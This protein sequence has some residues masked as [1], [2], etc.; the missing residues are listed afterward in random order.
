VVFGSVVPVKPGNGK[1]VRWDAC[2]GTARRG[3]SRH[4]P[5]ADVTTYTNDPEIPAYLGYGSYCQPVAIAD[6][7]LDAALSAGNPS[8]L[9][10]LVAY[11]VK[12]AAQALAVDIAYDCY[13]GTGATSVINGLITASGAAPALSA[14]G[15][16]AQV[17]RSEL[18]AYIGSGWQA[19]V[20]S[21]NGIVIP[22]TLDMLLHA[23]EITYKASGC[24]VDL[25]LM[26]TVAHELLAR[27][28]GNNRR[29]N[30]NIQLRGQPITLDGGFSALSWE[31]APLVRD[32]WCPE[33]Y[34]VGLCTEYVGLYQ[35]PVM[36]PGNMGV[37]ALKGSKE[38]QFGE[39]DMQL[40]CRV[41]RLAEAGDAM[42]I[43]LFAVPQL[44]V[45]RPQSCVLIADLPTSV[46]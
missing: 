28:F 34:I 42:K 35:P 12:Q 23:E 44:A 37:I 16:Y 3:T 11:K 30:Q 22:P 14:T 38:T 4:T 29:F 5:G 27:Q 1:D 43:G 25:W 2:L 8:E 26:N 31:G 17:S 13:L 7:A 6:D 39:S 10:N 24:R 40:T 36:A 32:I 19:N 33:G 45:E 41:K 15:T 20:I 21:N 9:S 18:S 46:S